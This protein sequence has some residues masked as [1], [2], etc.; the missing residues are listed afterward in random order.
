[1][2]HIVVVLGTRPEAVKMA[3]LILELKRNP[4]EFRVSVVSSGQHANLVN[5]ILT[6][7]G[8]KPDIAIDLMTP[9]QTLASLTSRAIEQMQNKLTELAPNWVVVQGD[10]TTA[11]ASALCAYY[12]NIPVAHLE[13]GLRTGR[14]DSP[15]PE[16]VN[17]RFIS[18]IATLHWAPTQL[19]ANALLK[20]GMP[21]AHSEIVVTG[22]T[23]IDA[24]LFSVAKLRVSAI[25]DLDR[26]RVESFLSS[27]EAN[28]FVLVT[29]HRRENFGDPIR[30]VC[31]AIASIAAIDPHVLFLL[32]VHPNPAVKESIG[33][34]LHDR[35]NIILASPKDYPEFVQL[36]DLCHLVVSDSG[37]LQ[38]EAPALGKKVLVTRETTE[39]SEGLDSGLVKLVGTCEEA[40]ASLIREELDFSRSRVQ[41]LSPAFPFGEGDAALKCVASLKRKC[42]AL[43][44]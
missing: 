36:L 28:R 13:A 8:I 40:L 18:Q 12:L 27:H 22:N 16:E 25:P 15:F 41:A 33:S 34:L 35:P 37:G 24:L 20:E 38:E 10:T 21:L 5:P 2:Q 4:S 7:F 26:A 32:P 39:R 42:T 43:A 30:K 14:I 9:R 3:P 31:A 29:A 44:A 11:M 19:A 23:V 6:F 17:R 1:M